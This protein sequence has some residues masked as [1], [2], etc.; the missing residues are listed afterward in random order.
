VIGVA[1]PRMNAQIDMAT[2]MTTEMRNCLRIV[3]RSVS[4]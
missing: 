2:I 4:E 1:K 3:S